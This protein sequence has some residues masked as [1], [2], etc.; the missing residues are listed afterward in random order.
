MGLVRRLAVE[1]RR[2]LRLIDGSRVGPLASRALARGEAGGVTYSLGS[3]RFDVDRC[4]LMVKGLELGCGA[5][6]I[7]G[8]GVIWEG[9]GSSRDIGGR[10]SS[11]DGEATMGA[12]RARGEEIEEGVD[13]RVC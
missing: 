2:L 3:K 9:E 4:V 7:A 5:L 8:P 1:W 13:D 6:L 12:A 10:L 11:R